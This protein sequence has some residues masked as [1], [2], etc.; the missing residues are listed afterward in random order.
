MKL[1]KLT[2]TNI[3]TAILVVIIPGAIYAGL[4]YLFVKGVIKNVKK[5][6]IKK[7]KNQKVDKPTARKCR[8]HSSRTRQR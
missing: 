1:P 7:N 2:K 4:A 6:S 3:A 8:R 5:T